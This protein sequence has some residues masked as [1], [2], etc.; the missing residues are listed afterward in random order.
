MSVRMYLNE[1]SLIPAPDLGTARGWLEECTLAMILSVESGVER[2]VKLPTHYYSIALYPGYYWESWLSDYEVS[3]ELRT[4]C[5]SLLT[6]VSF[7][8]NLMEIADVSC[9]WN[10]TATYGLRDA[11]IST[12]LAV[13]LPSGADW[14]VTEV[15][16][17]IERIEAGEL[18]ASPCK[19][20]HIS[21]PSHV[22]FHFQ[23]IFATAVEECAAKDVL[24]LVQRCFSRLSFCSPATSGLKKANYQCLRHIGRC[25]F[26]LNEYCRSWTSGPFD[27]R[28]IACDASV[29]SGSTLNQF[30]RERTFMCPDGSERLFSLHFKISGA[31]RIYFI[32]NSGCG[33]ATIGYIGPHLPTVDFPS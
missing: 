17:T 29:E 6:A 23:W 32:P 2:G 24:L 3:R 10:S 15:D 28:R 11:H 1:C 5:R 13:S 14:D 4:R 16:C 7:I 18:R 26:L 20:R 30:A 8:D 19:V 21:R 22:E 9:F 33:G 12:G 25:L 31:W 27:L